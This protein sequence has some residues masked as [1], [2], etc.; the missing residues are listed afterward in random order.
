MDRK[1]MGHITLLIQGKPTRK[2]ARIPCTTKGRQALPRAKSTAP[3]PDFHD[4]LEVATLM[5]EQDN[6]KD[7]SLIEVL[8]DLADF[9]LFWRHGGDSPPIERL[10]NLEG[11]GRLSSDRAAL[12]R[13]GGYAGQPGD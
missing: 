10:A 12:Q 7:D 9:D 2:V 13:D 8:R 4:V 3:F 6:K 11:V 5:Y 1:V